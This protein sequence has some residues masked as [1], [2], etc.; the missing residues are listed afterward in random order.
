[1]MAAGKNAHRRFFQATAGKASTYVVIGMIIGAACFYFQDSLL[2]PG[3][4]LTV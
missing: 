2:W 3:I 1:M 4:L